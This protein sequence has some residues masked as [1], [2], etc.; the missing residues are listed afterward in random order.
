VGGTLE[1]RPFSLMTYTEGSL[2]LRADMSISIGGIVFPAAPVFAELDN[3]LVSN[4]YCTM[5]SP[6][7]CFNPTSI[8]NLIGSDS[9][10]DT[11]YGL[12]SPITSGALSDP[13]LLVTAKTFRNYEGTMTSITDDEVYNKFGRY[14]YDSSLSDWV[15]HMPGGGS[16]V[17][18]SKYY[19]PFINNITGSS[20]IVNV[21]KKTLSI[22]E[23]KIPA[24]MP[25]N[26]IIDKTSYYCNIGDIIYL[27]FSSSIFAENSTFNIV[28]K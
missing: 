16:F 27:N 10:I 5:T 4:E 2:N 18:L 23:V 11:I 15:L 17:T 3:E 13:K 7:I 12:A 14:F 24:N 9:Y 25:Y 21:D 1:Y 26:G 28:S 22:K 20:T 8:Y 19:L 6:E